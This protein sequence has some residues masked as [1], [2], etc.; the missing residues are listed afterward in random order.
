MAKKIPKLRQ[1]L[2]MPGRRDAYDGSR[3]PP[4]WRM[5][6]SLQPGEKILAIKPRPRDSRYYDPFPDWTH[7]IWTGQYEGYGRGND[8]LPLFRTQR[9]AVQFAAAAYRAGYR[10]KK[11]KSK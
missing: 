2:N 5:N 9:N 6:T 1:P 11:S 8:G 3:I 4:L 10:I 7:D